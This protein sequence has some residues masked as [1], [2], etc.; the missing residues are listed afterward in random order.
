MKRFLFFLIILLIAA[1]FIAVNALTKTNIVLF[2]PVEGM[3]LK[4]I[5]LSYSLLAS[6]LLG[7][8]VTLAFSLFRGRKKPRTRPDPDFKNG[9]SQ[10]AAGNGA[11]KNGDT[12]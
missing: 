4:D 11:S 2:I 6:F 3:T 1:W 7:V 8:V 10:E 5:P 9:V 12:I